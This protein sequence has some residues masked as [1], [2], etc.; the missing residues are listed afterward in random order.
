MGTCRQLVLTVHEASAIEHDILEPPHILP[1]CRNRTVKFLVFAGGEGNGK[2]SVPSAS[3]AKLHCLAVAE[4]RLRVFNHSTGNNNVHFTWPKRTVQTKCSGSHQCRHLDTK[5]G[6]AGST[7]AVTVHFG[8]AH[9][10]WHCIQT[11]LFMR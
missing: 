10:R 9:D 5:A 3:K 1:G 6:T 7:D 11:R 2:F 4:G 8:R